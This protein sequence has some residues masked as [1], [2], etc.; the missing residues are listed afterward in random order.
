MNR[1]TNKE[2]PAKRLAHSTWF[3]IVY[4]LAEITLIWWGVYGES[5]GA[6]NLVKLLAA[7]N[8]IGGIALAHEMDKDKSPDPRPAW[9]R[10]F[11]DTCDIGIVFMTA[12]AG[13][14]WCATAFAWG[15]AVGSAYRSR[16]TK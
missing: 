9:L 12:W 15:A 5:V 6:A 13:W 3:C 8:F 16:S 11:L 10:R 14:W 1:D 7:W 4:A 2:E